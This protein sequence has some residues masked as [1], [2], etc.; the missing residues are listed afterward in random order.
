MGKLYFAQTNR[1]VNFTTMAFMIKKDI[2]FERKRADGVVWGWVFVQRRG[3]D[4][5]FTFIFYFFVLF[6]PPLWIFKIFKR[7]NTLSLSAFKSGGKNA[8]KKKKKTTNASLPPT[9]H[10]AKPPPPSPFSLPKKGSFLL[11][12]SLYSVFCYT[13]GFLGRI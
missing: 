10:L 7:H 11:P 1:C 13:M 9:H 3:G 5:F 2:F 12:L 4:D 8:T 6:C